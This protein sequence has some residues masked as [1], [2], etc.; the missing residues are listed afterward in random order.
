VKSKYVDLQTGEVISAKQLLAWEKGKD[1]IWKAADG[2][3]SLLANT[4][5]EAENQSQRLLLQASIIRDYLNTYDDA[6]EMLDG[7]ERDALA[8]KK[9]RVALVPPD[10]GNSFWL[11]GELYT[12]KAVGK[13]TGS[14]YT[15][16][17]AETSPKDESLVQRPH[18]QDVTFYVLE[19]ELEFMVEGNLSVVSAGYLLYVGRETW[20]AYRNVGTSSARHLKILTPA[21]IEKFFEE[22]S[23]PAQ[24]RSS[25]PPFEEED[26]E[27]IL[28]V[29]PK[30]GL[31]IQT[32]SETPT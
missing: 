30:Y 2:L 17:E 15:L 6:A 16:V 31:E 12:P 26:L 32:P 27:R 23:V 13:D 5:E 1:A 7:R 11:A 24:D 28:S 8:P 21:G 19:G 4:A 3:Y 10:E 29:A 22:V 9:Q 14:A 20:Y 25:P 18:R